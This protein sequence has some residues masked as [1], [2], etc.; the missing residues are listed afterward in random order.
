MNPGVHK[1]MSM[2]H[3]LHIDAL[4]CINFSSVKHTSKVLQ[5]EK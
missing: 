4:I 3:D 2:L 1:A 5:L